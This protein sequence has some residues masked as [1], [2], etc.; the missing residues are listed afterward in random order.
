MGETR[1]FIDEIDYLLDGLRITGPKSLPTIRASLEEIIEKCFDSLSAKFSV[2]VA[3]GMKLKSHGA[4]GTIFECLDECDDPVV[5]DNLVLLIG[6][7]L[8]DV[9]R[10]DFFLKP[11]S[12]I[13]LARHCL[14]RTAAAVSDSLID[15]LKCTQ[16]FKEVNT[17]DWTEKEI[18]MHV[19]IW[20]LYKWTF[21]SVTSKEAVFFSLLLK[22]TELLKQIIAV[23]NGASKDKI[24]EQAAGLLDALLNNRKC[25]SLV[26]VLKDELIGLL[27]KLSKKSS[28]LVH[29]KLV[30]SL[31]GS[32]LGP[33][34]QDQQDFFF[35]IVKNLIKI[36]VGSDNGE[37]VKILSLSSL[38]NLIDRC[39][40][41]ILDE[42]RYKIVEDGVSL[43]ECLSKEY[44]NPK[45]DA[46]MQ[47][48]LLALLLGFLC[49]QNRTNLQVMLRTAGNDN[50][51]GEIFT[52]ASNFLQKMGVSNDSDRV[53]IDRL[54][55]IVLTFKPQ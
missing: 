47:K 18:F 25:S 44:S 14:E 6:G 17:A 26:E 24:S 53:V 9:R 27:G 10:L 30:V 31:T 8:Y 35:E 3:F 20:L 32:P 15:K 28:S 46:S 5:L 21:S 43:L 40:D 22:E 1:R 51:K 45:S 34:L 12:S 16:V 39:D 36:G 7:L 41:F 4:L 42:F 55:E 38:I 50:V 52:V 48:S 54:S 29:M 13:K 11:E 33:S 37:E 23:I 49:R 19:A 2:N